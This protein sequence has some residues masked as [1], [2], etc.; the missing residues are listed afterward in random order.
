MDTEAEMS[1]DAIWYAGYIGSD[2]DGNWFVADTPAADSEARIVSGLS[3][4]DAEQIA[5]THNAE[6]ERL[7]AE[8]ER[9]KVTVAIRM[10]LE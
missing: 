2:R 4:R 10:G 6:I 5:K 8:N 7:R 3:Q 9:L 1:D